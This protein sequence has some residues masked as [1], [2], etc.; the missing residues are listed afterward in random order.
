MSRRAQVEEVSDSDPEEVA[1]SD[2][3]PQDDIISPSIMHPS[4][5]MASRPPPQAPQDIPK[6]FHCLYAVYFDKTRTRTEGRQ[7]SSKLA[8]ENPLARDILDACQQ[9]GLRVGFEPEKLHPKDWANPGRVR[10]MLKDEDG[11][12]L[13]ERVKNKHHL[14]ILVAQFLQAHPTTEKSPYRLRIHGLPMPDKLPDAPAAPRGWKIGKILPIHSPAYSGGGV[15]DN[16]FK[17]AM[18]EMEKMGGMPGM[19]GGMPGLPAGMANMM[20]M[21]EPSGGGEA[22]KKKEKKKIKA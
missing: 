12:L 10:V 11:N 13:N 4:P 19:P 5:G 18:A 2:P 17:E 8:V 9:L 14:Q 6:H 1:P 20:G 16:P 22:K 15:S 3:L 7:V 21:G